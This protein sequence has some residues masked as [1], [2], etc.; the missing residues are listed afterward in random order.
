MK[1]INTRIKNN[2]ETAYNFFMSFISQ[3]DWDKRKSNIQ[4]YLDAPVVDK[5]ILSIKNDVIGWYLFLAE[6]Y[7]NTNFNYQ[8]QQG[9][10]VIPLFNKIGEDLDLLK[11]IDGI[12]KKIRDVL[13]KRKNEADSLFFEILVALL[14]KR[15]GFKVSFL[16][17][18]KGGKTPD[19]LAIKNNDKWQIECKKQSMTSSY[20]ST[21][22]DK[23]NAIINKIA[24]NLFR[25][26]II[27]D[28]V[29]HVE[30]SSLPDDFLLVNAS[31]LLDKAESGIII[32]NEKVTI[33]LSYINISH[34]NNI[35]K[36][37]FFKNNSP[38]LIHLI[39][40]RYKGSNDFTYGCQPTKFSYIDNP[41]DYYVEEISNAFGVFSYC[42]A[43]EAINA[44]ARDIGNQIF[45]ATQQFD[46][47]SDSIIHIG[48]ETYDGG[49]IEV[50][51]AS[52]I[53]ETIKNLGNLDIKVKFIFCHFLQSYPTTYFDFIYDE[54]LLPISSSF[55]E[56]PIRKKMLILS[57][58]IE[59]VT[60]V[61]HWERPILD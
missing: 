18:G 29:F 20:K 44:K 59:T 32:D 41:E 16:P 24:N 8:P 46:S 57:D 47:T 31:K 48:L 9:A 11:K 43:E 3:N 56:Y 15:N 19:L 36:S 37:N 40:G 60:N 26:N 28:I 34:I 5:K 58:D 39:G 21:E 13:R 23:R 22:T 4:N 50:K 55:E 7:I 17:E 1:N 10:R 35:L 14:W 53:S 61:S 12:E 33:S 6:S 52:K 45:S 51:R 49:E 25:K 38:E 30:L 54:T 27:L 42:D 2:V